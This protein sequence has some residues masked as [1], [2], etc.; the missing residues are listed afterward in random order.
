MANTKISAL[1]AGNPAVGT[2]IIP[3]DRAGTNVSITAASVAA[4]A[5]ATSPQIVFHQVTTGINASIATAHQNDFTPTAVGRYRLTLILT[6]AVTDASGATIVMRPFNTNGN[7]GQFMGT[8]NNGL[9]LTVVGGSMCMVGGFVVPNATLTNF[10]AGWNVTVTGT[11]TT[12][13]WNM[14]MTVEYLGA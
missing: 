1:T 13:S 9:G 6:E 5:Q 4:L 10:K 14:D 3:I 8:T 11:P 2:D 12:G 7:I